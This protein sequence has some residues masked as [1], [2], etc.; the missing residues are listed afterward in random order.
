[1]LFSPAGPK[2]VINFSKDRKLDFDG[3]ITMLGIASIG[4]SRFLTL[5]RYQYYLDTLK[6]IPVG[7]E[8]ELLAEIV[9]RDVV[10]AP[11]DGEKLLGHAVLQMLIDR[12]EGGSLG[13][14]WQSAILNI[15]GDPRVPKSSPNY[16]QWWAILGEKRIALMRGWLS[17]FDL[18]LFLKV[19]EQSA[20][21]DGNTD[22]E[23]MFGPRKI[24][25]EGLLDQ[26]VVLES[27]LFLTVSA[28]SYLIQNYKKN[29]LPSYARVKGG[30]ASVIYLQ[31]EN[32]L[33]LI[34]GTHSFSIRVMNKLPTSSKLN[35]YSKLEF[36][37]RS[38]GAGLGEAY[39]REHQRDGGLLETAHYPELTWQNKVIDHLSLFKLKLDVG[40][41]ISPSKYREYKSKFGVY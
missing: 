16:Q 22:M 36:Q 10:N 12:S 8:H 29:E 41:L 20:K 23:R 13:H 9:K 24:F 31:L 21:D 25:M 28:E 3:A 40:G 14:A 26:K 2:K 33:H 30:Q 1:M 6:T 39:I 19:L 38:L 15:A 18:S 37:S 5:C 27:R 34:E 4:D 17:R 11:F 32:G 7:S 35:D